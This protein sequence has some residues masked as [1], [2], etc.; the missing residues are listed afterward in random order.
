MSINPAMSH[1]EDIAVL[2]DM[3]IG[4]DVLDFALEER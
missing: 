1:N 4:V 2:G 3:D